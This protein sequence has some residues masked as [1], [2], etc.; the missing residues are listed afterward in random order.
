METIRRSLVEM[1]Q[2]L[3]NLGTSKKCVLVTEKEVN[4]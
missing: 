2:D 4:E 1:L 3:A